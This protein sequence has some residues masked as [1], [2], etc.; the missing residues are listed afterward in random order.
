MAEKILNGKFDSENYFFLVYR[1]EISEEDLLILIY[2][3]SC[4]IAGYD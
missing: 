4:K 1:I 2:N 3:L